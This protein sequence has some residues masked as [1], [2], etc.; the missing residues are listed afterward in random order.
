MKIKALLALA[1]LPLLGAA[2]STK[3]QVVNV[4][5]GHVVWQFPASGLSEKIYFEHTDDG[6]ND[7][8]MGF[9]DCGFRTTNVDSI[10]VK[11]VEAPSSTV[12]IK[13]DDTEGA[14]VTFAGD[15]ACYMDAVVNG[16]HVSIV[17][18]RDLEKEVNYVLTGKSTN[19]SFYMDGHYKASLTLN[20]VEL[21]NPDSAALCIE[22]GKRIAVTLTDGTTNT[23]TDG[24]GGTQKA[25]FFINGHAEISGGGTL[26]ITGNTKHAYAS[27]EYTWLKADCGA[28]NILASANDGMHI[29]QYYKQEGGTVNVKG[30]AGDCIDVSITNDSTDVQNGEVIIAGGVLTMDV[31][32][33]DVKGLKSE[34]NTTISGGTIN[35]TVSGDGSKGMSVGG[36]LT[37]G[38]D[39]G[40]T[41]QI[42]MTVSGT[43]YH[44]G[45]EDESKCRGI[46]VKGNYTLAGG[47]IHM[48]VTGKKAKGIA[49]DGNYTYKG[50]TTN[51]VPE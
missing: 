38:Q 39:E 51:V 32:A 19:G 45:Q 41:T 1:C 42:T 11:T 25:C 20:G 2:Q 7:P 48:D 43:T 3:T 9:A 27:D 12:Q 23:F 47:N 49:I 5:Q 17:A 28:I 26:N 14:W 6:N 46:K 24:T 37:I 36:D 18:A 31:A 30:T 4:Y 22:D 50:G 13:Y 35:A 21:T 15:V 16:N 33:E 29:E 44:K 10:V 8:M 34:N 40:A